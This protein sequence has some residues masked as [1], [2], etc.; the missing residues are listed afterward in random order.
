MKYDIS[1]DQ[2]TSMDITIAVAGADFSG[3]GVT[4]KC[5]FRKKASADSVAVASPV[6]SF[7][8]ATEINLKL[9]AVETAAI[10]V[11]ASTPDTYDSFYYDIIVDLGAD[12]VVKPIYGAVKVTPAVTR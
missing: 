12:V 9:T 1:L 10:P 4:G 8:T 2:G 11:S 7:P 6:V 3:V 5:Q